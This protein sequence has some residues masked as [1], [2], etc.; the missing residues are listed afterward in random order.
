MCSDAAK[1]LLAETW[2]EDIDPTGWWMSEKLDGVRAYWNGKNFYSRQGNLFHAPDFFKAAL[3]KV[4]LD[5]EIWC[6]R[7][8]FQKCVSIVKKQADKVVPDDYKLLTYLIFDAPS[9]GGKYEDRMKWLQANI[10]QDDDKCFATVVGIKKCEGLAQLKQFLADVNK[11]GGEG[12]MLRKPGSLY[13]HKR[14][15]TLLKV[16]TFHDEEAL[17]IGHKPS[18]S[19]VGMVGA[20]EC[21][22]TNGKR[23]DVGSGLTMDQRRKAPKIGSIITFKFQ[24]LSNNGHPRFPVFLRVRTDL[25]WNDVLEAAK[26]KKPMSVIQKVIPS[27]K[28]SKQHSILFSVIPSRD[29]ATGKKIVTSDD[30]DDDE[31]TQPSTS[32]KTTDTRKMCQ[33]GANCYRTNPD[34]LKQYQHSSSTQTS[35]TTENESKTKPIC[36]FGTKCYR[37]SSIHL[38]TYSHP[39]KSET[40]EE[41]LDTRELIESEEPVSPTTIDSLLVKDKNKGLTFDDDNDDKQDQEMISRPKQEWIDLENKLKE[42]SKRLAYLEEMFKTTKRSISANGDDNGNDN[43]TK[44]LKTD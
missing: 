13:E 37:K 3:P 33:F 23:F 19:L 24:E 30:E 25:T 4:P 39:S 7:G 27:T 10:P 35:K 26:T 34:H 9:H 43:N 5:G 40:E 12:I 22:L 17:V 16:K 41:I 44:R 20:L 1:V 15:T 28:L 8:L 29:V 18:K 38:A 2:T 42:Q 14:S 21:E 36:T 32:S 31:V 6:G 11:A